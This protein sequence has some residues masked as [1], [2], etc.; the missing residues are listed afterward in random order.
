MKKISLKEIK[1]NEEG[2]TFEEIV[3]N[4]I[5]SYLEDVNE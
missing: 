4:L 1:Y 2:K 5:F 3:E